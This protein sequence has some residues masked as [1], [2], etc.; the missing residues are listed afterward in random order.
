M[1]FYIRAIEMLCSQ[2]LIVREREYEK[3]AEYFVG[4]AKAVWRPIEAANGGS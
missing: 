1:I 3:W 4:D 2:A